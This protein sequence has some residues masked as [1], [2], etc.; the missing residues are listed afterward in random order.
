M[1]QLRSLPGVAARHTGGVNLEDLMERVRTFADARSWQSFHTPKNLVMALSG[2]VGELTSLFQWLTPAECAAWRD[3][4]TLAA[5]VR[6]EIADVM[7]YLLRLADVL[8]VDLLAAANAKIDR[9][10]VRFPVRTNQG[11]INRQP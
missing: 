10:E 1:G 6:D 11:A 3:D 8:G 4:P 5:N 2:E 7:L 9:N